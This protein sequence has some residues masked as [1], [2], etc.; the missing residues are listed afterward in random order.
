MVA[1][2][3]GAFAASTFQTLSHFSLMAILRG[4]EREMAEVRR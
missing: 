3:C 4:T 1:V 2:L